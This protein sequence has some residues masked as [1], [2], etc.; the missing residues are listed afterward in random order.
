MCFA[1]KTELIKKVEKIFS[2]NV[3]E[4]GEKLW[5]FLRRHTLGS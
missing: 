1:L 3:I 4:S 2:Q 5:E